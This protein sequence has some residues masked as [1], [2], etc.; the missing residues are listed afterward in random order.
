MARPALES[1]TVSDSSGRSE[2]RGTKVRKLLAKCLGERFK[3]NQF[4]LHDRGFRSRCVKT[5][6]DVIGESVY[7]L[8]DS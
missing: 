3:K 4:C 2:S 1:R 8:R 6:P 7:K 5:I